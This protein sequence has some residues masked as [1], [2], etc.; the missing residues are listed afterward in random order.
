MVEVARL[1]PKQ[2]HAYASYRM[3]QTVL[4]MNAEERRRRVTETETVRMEMLEAKS[5]VQRTIGTDQ[6]FEIQEAEQKMSTSRRCP[7]ARWPAWRGAAG[8][9]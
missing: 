6:D 5:R 7:T 1:S 8:A 3:Y 4:L 9:A 2:W